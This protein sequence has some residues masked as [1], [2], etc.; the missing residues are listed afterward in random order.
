MTRFLFRVHSNTWVIDS[1]EVESIPE[2][3]KF[4]A[5]CTL[6]YCDES[7]AYKAGAFELHDIIIC[8]YGELEYKLEMDL[9]KTSSL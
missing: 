7:G 1:E 5:L 2:E 3:E 8:R 9:H 4:L 6:H